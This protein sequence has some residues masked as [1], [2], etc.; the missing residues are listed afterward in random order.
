[1]EGRMCKQRRAH[2]RMTTYELLHVVP[3]QVLNIRVQHL[4]PSMRQRRVEI[5]DGEPASQGMTNQGPGR[6]DLPSLVQERSFGRE[7]RQKKS[8]PRT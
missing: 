1:V 2:C 7:A 6:P 8:E 4:I 3:G 5:A